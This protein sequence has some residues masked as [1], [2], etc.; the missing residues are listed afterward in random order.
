MAWL[1]FSAWR[2]FMTRPATVLLGGNLIDWG[3]RMAGGLTQVSWA[4]IRPLGTLDEIDSVLLCRQP[5]QV[6]SACHPP[7]QTLSPPPYSLT[8]TLLLLR[9]LR[10]CYGAPK[11]TPSEQRGVKKQLLGRLLFLSLFWVTREANLKYSSRPLWL[12]LG[13]SSDFSSPLD[14]RSHSSSMAQCPP[15]FM[16]PAP[17]ISIHSN[18][19]HTH[20]Q[21]TCLKDQNKLKQGLCIN[22]EGWDVAGDGEGG[23]K[24]RGYMYSYGWFMLRFA[25]NNK[26]L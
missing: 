19:T 24:G 4:V 9:I 23:S 11:T 22:L 14:S 18:H 2:C 20:T 7:A 3:Q 8:L 26:I 10:Q 15:W 16:H 17:I 25:E 1:T 21:K 6:E 5:Q 13:T 12:T